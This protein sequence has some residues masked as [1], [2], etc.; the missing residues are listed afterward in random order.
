MSPGFDERKIGGHVSLHAA[1]GLNIGMFHPEQLLEALA[2]QVFDDIRE[3]AAGI[4]T[5]ARVSLCVFLCESRPLRFHHRMARVVLRGDED[6]RIP[7]PSPLRPRIAA[8]ISG[9]D[10]DKCDMKSPLSYP[11]IQYSNG[12]TGGRAVSLPL[13]QL[14]SHMRFWPSVVNVTVPCRSV[15]RTTGEDAQS[16]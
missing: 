7:L 9:S 15:R 16:V 2:C 14:L 1:V 6:N 10:S 5:S 11:K 8:K 12:H 4:V 13:V 3:F